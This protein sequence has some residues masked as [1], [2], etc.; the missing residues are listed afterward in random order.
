M[1]NS[2]KI[3]S[4]KVRPENSNQD[5]KTKSSR[6]FSVKQSSDDIK[7]KFSKCVLS[8]CRSCSFCLFP[9][10]TTKER[11]KSLYSKDR[12]KR[13]QRCFLCKSMSFCPT[14]SKCP[15]CCPKFGCRGQATE[16][17]ACLAHTGC[18]SKGGLNFE[19]GIHATLQNQTTSDQV[20]CDQEWLCSP[21]EKQGLIP[22]ID[23]THKQ[24]GG[25]KSGDKVLPGL[26]QPP[27]SG[28]KIQ[29]QMEAYL[30]PQPS[31]PILETRHLQFRRLPVRSSVRSGFAHSGQMGHSSAE[32]TVHQRQEKL[33]SQTV[34]VSNRTPYCNRETGMGRLPPHETRSVAPEATLA[35]T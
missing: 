31:K 7:F 16:V 3:N 5:C 30:G 35:C 4:Y 11:Y 26:L 27:F 10:A 14:C 13:C 17:L 25:R 23:R 6:Q 28:T 12:N 34:H 32:T 20:P 1:S 24:V 18:E 29:P 9:R 2:L 15:H 8:C 19:K 21:G 33:L 22:S